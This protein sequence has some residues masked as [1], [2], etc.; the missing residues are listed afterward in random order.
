MKQFQ[1]IYQNIRGMKSKVDSL[2]ELV[3]DQKPTIVCL[4]ETHLEKEEEVAIP[5][6]ETIY[7]NDKTANSILVA[8]KEIIK[9]VTIQT[10]KE[11][12]VGEGPWIPID[13]KKNKLKLAVI[14]APQENKTPNNELKKM[15]QETK[16]QIE[17][18]RQ[19]CQNIIL[20]NF[21]AKIRAGIKRNK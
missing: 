5:G 16:D 15:Y 9:T 20:G 14:Y 19:Q 18:A 11:K 4:V 10:H 8:V 21:N 12:Q 7:R 6:Y 13:N 2:T 3:E 17:Q 1:I